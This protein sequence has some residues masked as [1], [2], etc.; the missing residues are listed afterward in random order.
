MPTRRQPPRAA[1]KTGVLPAGSRTCVRP[2]AQ[3][4]LSVCVCVDGA[5]RVGEIK[6]A[7]Q[8][9]TTGST[10]PHRRNA[11]NA[12]GRITTIRRRRPPRRRRRKTGN[13]ARWIVLATR[14]QK[15]VRRACPFQSMPWTQRALRGALLSLSQLLARC[16]LH[17]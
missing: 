15:C 17:L 4:V 11:R 5:G 9:A 2:V 13:Q 6:G 16:P 1:G 14:K 7:A 12:R 3:S 10:R 8:A